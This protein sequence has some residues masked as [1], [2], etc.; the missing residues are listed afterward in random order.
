[1]SESIEETVIL[2]SGTPTGTPATPL[3]DPV[4]P[5]RGR[6]VS[7]T[8][9]VVTRRVPVLDGDA[10][11]GFQL[12]TLRKPRPKKTRHRIIPNRRGRR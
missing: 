4:A 3:V 6:F 12:G 7:V 10:P 11:E 1:M 2:P 8:S 5:S 9:G